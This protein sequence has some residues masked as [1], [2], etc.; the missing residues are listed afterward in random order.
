MD[1]VSLYFI[2]LGT[3]K[4]KFGLKTLKGPWVTVPL[5][6]LWFICEL[7]LL[8]NVQSMLVM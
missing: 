8:E 6:G 1:H 5:Q 7:R 4:F 2:N 3:L